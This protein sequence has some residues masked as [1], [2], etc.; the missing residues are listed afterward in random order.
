MSDFYT[1]RFTATYSYGED[2]AEVELVRY[3]RTLLREE[4]T[5]TW[6]APYEEHQLVGGAWSRVV[7]SG[8]AS[9]T[10]G[11]SLLL[12]APRVALAEEAARRLEYE[13]MLHRE[14]ELVLLEAFDGDCPMLQTTWRAVVTACE[15]KLCSAEEAPPVRDGTAWALVTLEFLLTDKE[16]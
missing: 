7:T 11:L 12:P 5:R 6:S 8:N 1:A 13:L 10:L 14:G 2:A 4:P 15:S 16:D 3:G 9:L